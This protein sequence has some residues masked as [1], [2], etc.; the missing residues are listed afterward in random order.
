M[1]SIAFSDKW[2]DAGVISAALSHAPVTVYSRKLVYLD[3]PSQDKYLTQITID[4][5]LG[6]ASTLLSSLGVI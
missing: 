1:I 3:N 2:L 6:I 5:P 4:S